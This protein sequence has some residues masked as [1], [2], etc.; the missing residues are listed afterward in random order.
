M[1]SLRD[2]ACR[3]LTTNTEQF[4][5]RKRVYYD[6]KI[7]IILEFFKSLLF[8]T[9]M[10]VHLNTRIISSLWNVFSFS[11]SQWGNVLYLNGEI[12]LYSSQ[13]WKALLA[14]L[15]H[16]KYLYP[17][18]K[19]HMSVRIFDEK[20]SHFQRNMYYYYYCHHYYHHCYY[21]YLHTGY[22]QLCTWI[23]PCL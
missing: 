11:S 7:R 19:R 15:R 2:G 22:L 12:P 1:S 4:F 14:I 16:S 3:L 10:T 5:L 21:Y 20:K 23:K 13:K 9:K 17:P 18:R 8:S 6:Y